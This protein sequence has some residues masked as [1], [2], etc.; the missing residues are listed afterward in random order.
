M[1]EMKLE[2]EHLHEHPH[3]HDQGHPHEYP[4]G[5]KHPHHHENTKYVQNRLAYGELEKEVSQ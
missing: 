3:D 1:D 5:H 4:D 2:P